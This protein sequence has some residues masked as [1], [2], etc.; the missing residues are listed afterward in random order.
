MIKLETADWH[1]K[2]PRKKEEAE[3]Y[4]KLI[5][6]FIVKLD[7][8]IK[9]Y[10][11]EELD[12]LG[13]VFDKQPTYLDVGV[14]IKILNSLLSKHPKLRIN[15]I[16]GN[17]D[18][19]RSNYYLSEILP[20][21]NNRIKLYMRCQEVDNIIYV[22]NP[23]IR[24]DGEI[25]KNYDKI[26]FS[27]IAGSLP[28]FNKEEEYSFEE[29]KKYKF[30]ILGDLHDT[31]QVEENIY[32]T[33]SPF[34]V[35]KKSIKNLAEI[36]NSFYGVLIFDTDSLKVEKVKLNLP[37]KYKLITD[38]KV[39]REELKKYEDYIE[40]EYLVTAENMFTEE[41]EDMESIKIIRKIDIQELNKQK[42]KEVLEQLLKEKYGIKD[43]T[44]F[45]QIIERIF[46]AFLER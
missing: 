13:D 21:L 11:V 15:V 40:I 14:L 35:Y 43:I 30:V 46:P 9:E 32:Y 45:I 31:F 4:Y 19:Y 8:I 25:P 16:H 17:H 26:V 10:K 3:W 2:V 6:K 39:D 28:M 41:L 20:Y 37:N 22:D 36:D 33:G 44:P 29:L 27:H 24:Y 12:L 42:N 1:I 18:F 5:D 23:Y 7:D 38:K 34:R